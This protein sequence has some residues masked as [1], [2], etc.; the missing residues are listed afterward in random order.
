MALIAR[1]M[2]AAAMQQQLLVGLLRPALQPRA[3]LFPLGIIPPDLADFPPPHFQKH[4]S[5]RFPICGSSGHP[6]QQ[7]GFPYGT[8]WNAECV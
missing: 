6:G 1:V 4:F 2:E 5:S 8:N 3:G 7:S